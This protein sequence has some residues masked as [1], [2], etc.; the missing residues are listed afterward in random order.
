MEAKSGTLVVLHGNLVHFR[1]GKGFFLASFL[2][3]YFQKKKSA[4]NTSD[5]SREAFTMHVTDASLQWSPDN[6][7][8]L[9]KEGFR[10]WQKE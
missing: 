7:L 10:V 2:I 1:F 4:A 5:R 3:F 8:T 6:W 9:P